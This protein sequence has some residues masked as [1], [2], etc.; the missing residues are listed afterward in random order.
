VTSTIVDVAGGDAARLASE[1]GVE[2]STLD[3]MADLE[4]AVHVLTSIWGFAEGA[5]PVSPELLRALAFAGG[6]VAAARADG[7]I[8]GASAGFLGRHP[9]D[10]DLHLHSHISGVVPTWQGRHVGLALKQHQRAWALAAGIDT[11]E[12]TFD[13]LV[14]RNAFFNLVKLGAEIVGFEPSF[15]GEMT[16]SINAGDETDRAVVRWTLTAD[17]ATS[18]AQGFLDRDQPDGTMILSP[19]RDGLPLVA[20]ASGDVLR[21]WVPE[22]AVALRGRDPEAGRAWRRAL[23]KTFGDAVAGGYRATSMTRD[24]WYT[25]VRS[26]A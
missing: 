4:E 17:A 16:D 25:L 24:G 15:Y 18:A 19:G 13:P 10:D 21:A 22:D 11:I 2:V 26:D 6:Y 23:R 3:R 5:V 7:H 14:R 8:V 1:A 9:R 20:A 12:W